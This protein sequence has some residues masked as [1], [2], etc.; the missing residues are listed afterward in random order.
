MMNI[1]GSRQHQLLKWLNLSSLP[2]TTGGFL[3]AMEEFINVDLRSIATGHS[4]VK[5]QQANS[6]DNPGKA[7]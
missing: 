2:C 1:D 7:R 6:S 3:D 4:L 5:F